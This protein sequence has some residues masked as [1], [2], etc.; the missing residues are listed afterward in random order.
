MNTPAQYKL[1]MYTPV[2]YKLFM[3]TPVQNKISDL[4]GNIP[5]SFSDIQ[6]SVQF[7]SDLTG[8]ITQWV[9]L[10]FIILISH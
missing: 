8:R 5:Y 1:F 9:D 6:K 2:Q 4:E 7:C 10:Q 3:Y